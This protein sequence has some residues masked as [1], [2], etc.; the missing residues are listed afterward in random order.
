MHSAVC[1][2]TTGSG[3]EDF[4]C[5]YLLCEVFTFIGYAFEYPT[6]LMEWLYIVAQRYNVLLT[7]SVVFKSKN[8]GKIKFHRNGLLAM[9]S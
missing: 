9:L 8:G 4:Y 3:N 1:V 7:F 5:M 6:I 2:L